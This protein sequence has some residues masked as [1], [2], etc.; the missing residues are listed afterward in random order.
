M[1]RPTSLIKE[2]TIIEKGV[3]VSHSIRMSLILKVRQQEE[4]TS[5]QTHALLIV[6]ICYLWKKT[7]SHHAKMNKV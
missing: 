1:K 2:K 5:E 6:I 4:N 3:F 7:Q